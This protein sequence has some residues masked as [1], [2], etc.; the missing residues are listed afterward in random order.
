MPCELRVQP[1]FKFRCPLGVRGTFKETLEKGL[2]FHRNEGVNT[3]RVKDRQQSRPAFWLVKTEIHSASIPNLC[4]HTPFRACTQRCCAE[5]GYAVGMSV[6]RTSWR[7]PRLDGELR[8]L[9]DAG[10]SLDVAI[11]KLWGEIGWGRME[12]AASVAAT[13]NCSGR[14]ARRLVVKATFDQLRFMGE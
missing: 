3:V 8:A 9:L 2:R 11:Q 10:Y 14:E 5:G 12:L 7:N 13:C 6:Y 1:F 4:L